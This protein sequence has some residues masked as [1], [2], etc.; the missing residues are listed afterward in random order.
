MKR[1]NGNARKN[2]ALWS[3][4]AGHFVF[5]AEEYQKCYQLDIKCG[6]S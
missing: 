5:K 3:A 6:S 2:Y 4:N 1:Y